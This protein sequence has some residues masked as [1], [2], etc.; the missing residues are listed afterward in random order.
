MKNR[1]GEKTRDE[2]LKEGREKVMR[3]GRRE[4]ISDEE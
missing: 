2:R 3:G 1:R 4:R